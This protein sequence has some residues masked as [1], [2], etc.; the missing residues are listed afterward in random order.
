VSHPRRDRSQKHQEVFMQ[1]IT[2][3]FGA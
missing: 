3:E 1:R 2:E